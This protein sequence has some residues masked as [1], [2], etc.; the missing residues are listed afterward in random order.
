MDVSRD[1]FAALSRQLDAGFTQA[2]SIKRACR[3]VEECLVNNRCVQWA[4]GGGL[5]M[6]CK[7]RRITLAQGQLAG[8]L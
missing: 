4:G 1:A 3:A 2:G 8:L 7:T 5:S 6:R